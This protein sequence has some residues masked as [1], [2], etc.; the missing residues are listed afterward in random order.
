M[1]CFSNTHTQRYDT[2]H[3]H[4]PSIKQMLNT[5]GLEL[6]ALKRFLLK[7]KC[8]IVLTKKKRHL[9]WHLTVHR[10][11]ASWQGF[12]SYIELTRPFFS[13]ACFRLH[14]YS[15]TMHVCSPNWGFSV[16]VPSFTCAY[17]WEQPFYTFD[18]WLEHWWERKQSK[19]VSY[20]HTMN[21]EVQKEV[22]K[23]GLFNETEGIL[24]D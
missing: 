14:L 5:E 3:F 21:H 15:V 12:E 13:F 20:I 22:N 18:V 17:D 9:K 23:R 6:Y 11:S 24:S 10:F 2:V 8:N 1:E 4:I 19:W 7:V 16:V